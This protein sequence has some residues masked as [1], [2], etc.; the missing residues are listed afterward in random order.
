MRYASLLPPLLLALTVAACANRQPAYYVTNSMTGQRVPTGQQGTSDN[1]RGLLGAGETQASGYNSYASAAPRQQQSSGRGLFNS[2]VFHSNVFQSRWLNRRS[3]APRYAAQPQAPR[4]YGSRTYAS[5]TYAPQ[6]YSYH[7]PRQQAYAQRST[8]M[9]YRPP[10]QAPQRYTPQQHYR[11]S[12]LQ[13]TGY[14]TARYG[15]Y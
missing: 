8:T 7:P 2:H 14:Y 12:Q 9:Q 4:T 11:A 6:T 15:L 3:P 10:Q 5:H 1:Q 13:P